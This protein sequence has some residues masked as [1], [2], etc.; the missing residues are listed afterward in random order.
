MKRGFAIATE[1][2]DFFVRLDKTAV[3]FVFFIF[4]GLRV[5]TLIHA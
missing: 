3:S 5:N 2:P 1:T 4:L